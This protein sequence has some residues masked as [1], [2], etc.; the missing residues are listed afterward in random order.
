MELHYASVAQLV[1]QETFNLWVVG[2][3]PTG[4][5]KLK[6][7]R[8]NMTSKEKTLERYPTAYAVKCGLDKE[9]T[10]PNGNLELFEIWIKYK[11][12]DYDCIGGGMTE[13]EAWAEAA[14]TD[15]QPL[16]KLY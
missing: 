14:I 7:L 12:D 6:A 10:I 5:T 1:E 16:T 4:R 8:F 9:N 3:S 2:S 11:E 15:S 13:E